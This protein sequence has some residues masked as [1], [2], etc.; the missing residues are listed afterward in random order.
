VANVVASDVM[1]IA[2]G[3]ESVAAAIAAMPGVDPAKLA[4]I[5]G[6]VATIQKD[7]ADI[8]AATATPAPTT[9]SEIAQV[10]Q[11]LAPIALAVVPGGSALV[12]VVNAAVSMLPTVLA[13]AGV[14]GAIA[15]APTYTPEQARMILAATAR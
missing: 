4:Q 9:I 2:Q 10:V 6:Y 3:I 7:A 5:R 11:A 1:L 14:S 8:A 15:T 13:A 12:P